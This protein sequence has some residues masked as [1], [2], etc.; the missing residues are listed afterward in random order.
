M[1]G[2]KRTRDKPSASDASYPPGSPDEYGYDSEEMRVS[3]KT[4]TAHLSKTPQQDVEASD[5]LEGVKVT[6]K[7]TTKKKQKNINSKAASNDSMA[8]A[9]DGN[10]E[11]DPTSSPPPF[12]LL[13]PVLAADMANNT[14]AP[15][16][17]VTRQH[18]INEVGQR[19]LHPSRTPLQTPSSAV[20]KHVR[21]AIYERFFLGM[22]NEECIPNYNKHGGSANG[23]A[24]VS[25]ALLAGGATWFK[26]EDVVLPWMAR[27]AD[28]KKRLKGL[29]LAPKNFP[30]P[31]DTMGSLFKKSKSLSVAPAPK[32]VENTKEKKKKVRKPPGP[33]TASS[34]LASL[35]TSL[36][37]AIK[38]LPKQIKS[39]SANREPQIDTEISS[40][41]TSQHHQI[42]NHKDM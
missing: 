40:R 9:K 35:G 39:I 11:E 31:H 2:I 4:K 21:Y 38:S 36:Q 33:S 22:T 23:M 14:Y 26:E 32:K 16:D 13:A 15:T 12:N 34:V 37:Y 20:P 28:A 7:K 17:A 18:Y 10:Q 3:K 24:A 6:K 1:A 29:G 42:E 41:Q 19:Q 27:R 5:E 30:A 25:K 8:A